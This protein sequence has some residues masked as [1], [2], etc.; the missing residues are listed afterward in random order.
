MHSINV[1]MKTEMFLELFGKSVQ[2]PFRALALRRPR[3]RFLF[4]TKMVVVVVFPL[5]FWWCILSWI[6]IKF[7]VLVAG[8]I[9]F[10]SPFLTPTVSILILCSPWKMSFQFILIF[11]LIRKPCKDRHC[12]K[13]KAK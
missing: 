7:R 11:S 13:V 6:F 12:K 9:L 4:C 1:K 3:L 10:P 2:G 8:K 5:C